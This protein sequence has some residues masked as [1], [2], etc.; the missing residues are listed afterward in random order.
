M[1][2]VFFVVVQDAAKGQKWKQKKIA[3]LYGLAG[4]F[5]LGLWM[6]T[7]FVVQDT[8]NIIG[9]VVMMELTW[10]EIAQTMQLFAGVK[11]H[12]LLVRHHACYVPSL[13]ARSPP[14]GIAPRRSCIG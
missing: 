1:T 5:A 2:D 6:Y 13:R 9:Y 8:N 12:P 10:I 14:P 3:M 4:V 7:W 11:L